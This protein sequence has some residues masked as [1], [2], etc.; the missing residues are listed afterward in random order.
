[1]LLMKICDFVSLLLLLL[2]RR[3]IL[4]VCANFILVWFRG[5]PI[6][7]Y[8]KTAEGSC[9]PCENRCLGR[10]SYLSTDLWLI[11]VTSEFPGTFPVIMPAS[12]RSVFYCRE[13]MYR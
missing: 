1:M 6:C 3:W 8:G 9:L 11:F 2:L 4:P 12:E 5:Y 7:T 13:N 10:H